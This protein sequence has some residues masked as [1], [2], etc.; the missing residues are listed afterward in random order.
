MK[1]VAILSKEFKSYDGEFKIHETEIAGQNIIY[2][3]I[4]VPKPNFNAEVSPNDVLIEKKVSLVIIEISAIYLYA[5]SKL[6]MMK[7]SGLSFVS[8]GSEFCGIVRE[9][10]K[11]VSN[12]NIGDK[13]I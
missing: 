4:D 9:K 3:L 7:G 5:N 2:G 12:L 13:V 8:I 6:S 1:V 10:G 11:L